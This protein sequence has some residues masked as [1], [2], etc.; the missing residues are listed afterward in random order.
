MGTFSNWTKNGNEGLSQKV[1]GRV[2]PET[3]IKNKIENVQ[4]KLELQI[5]KLSA[6]SAKIQ[7]KHDHIF[8]KIVNAQKSNNH[9]YAKAYA[10]ELQE[11]RKMNNMV[12]NAK[13]SMEQI[14]IRLN[15]VSELGDVVVTLSPCMSV[16]KGLGVSLGGI[17]PQANSSMQDLSKILGDV[18]SGSTVGPEDTTILTRGGNADTVAILEEAQAVIEGQT[19]ENIPDIPSNLPEDI[20]SE[21]RERSSI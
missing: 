13:L 6:I 20:L 9:S 4:Q 8:E 2:K 10:I 16:I 1:F 17:M 18:L 21:R 11:I 14:N 15:T 5:M 12:S 3:P 19:K 7:K